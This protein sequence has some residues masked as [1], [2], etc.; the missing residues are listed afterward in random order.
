MLHRTVG[1]ACH[2]RN[3][4]VCFFVRPAVLIW[5]FDRGVHDDG[6]GKNPDDAAQAYERQANRQTG[7][8]RYDN[9]RRSRQRAAAVACA[10]TA[11]KEA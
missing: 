6:E 7:D 9:S 1:L 4:T 3:S 11:P 2:K 8:G 10:R 5:D